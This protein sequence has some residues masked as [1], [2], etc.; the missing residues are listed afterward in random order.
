MGGNK[1]FFIVIGAFVAVWTGCMVFTYFSS[2]NG[3][4][5][6]F[7]IQADGKIAV[8]IAHTPTPLPAYPTPTPDV[9]S[10]PVHTDKGII[11]YL[12]GCEMKCP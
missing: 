8:A 1:L 12:L 9:Q 10:Q 3:M 2:G 11:E 7:N 5:V 6:V 4:P